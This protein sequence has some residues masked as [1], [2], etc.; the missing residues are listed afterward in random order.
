MAIA[1]KSREL[2]FLTEAYQVVK[3]FPANQGQSKDSQLAEVV[4]DFTGHESCFLW[5][6]GGGTLSIVKPRS[7]LVEDLS[8]F[9]MNKAKSK[10]LS[11]I[12]AIIDKKGT[13]VVGLAV[14]E[15][16]NSFHFI[17]QETKPNG[18]REF[19]PSSKLVPGQTD[20]PACFEISLCQNYLYLGGSKS[21]IA[22]ILCLEFTNTLNST[23]GKKFPAVNAAKVS[24]IK[25]IEGSEILVLG[26]QGII[27]VGM[28]S[29]DKTS[30][31]AIHTIQN[32]SSTDINFFTFCKNHIIVVDQST[33]IIRG[34]QMK[35][36]NMLESLH[37]IEYENDPGLVQ[38]SGN[39]LG[40]CISDLLINLINKKASPAADPFK[41]LAMEP[42]VFAEILSSLPD[43]SELVDLLLLDNL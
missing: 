31:D 26:C 10:L 4:L 9:W 35:V 33:G 39:E 32:M 3:S 13:Q 22:T 24:K 36:N 6:R 43:T 7:A 2:Q 34:V 25:R 14:D 21:S 1:P 41:L 8:Q 40:S 28:Y 12:S 16:F 15:Q 20:D 17:F 37:H 18:L 11:P 19:V 30:F 29:Q 27:I 42:Q 5:N 38:E 23:C